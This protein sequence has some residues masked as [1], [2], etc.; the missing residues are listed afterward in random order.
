MGKNHHEPFK[1]LSG[2]EWDQVA[3][4]D[5][6]DFLDTTFTDALAVVDSIPVP[7]TTAISASASS[8]SSPDPSSASASTGGRARAHTD[9]A[10]RDV[11]LD[12]VRK[13]AASATPRRQ[14]AEAMARA[15][16]LRKEWKE[17]KVG[18]AGTPE[19][20]LGINVY[21]LGAKD[22]RGSWFARRSVHADLSFDRWRLG[23]EHEFAETMK[24]QTGPGGGSIRG[25]GAERVVERHV[26]ET[27]GRAEVFQLSAQFPGPTAPRDFITLLLSSDAQAQSKSADC[28]REFIIVSKPCVHPECPPR[29]G[30]I[31]GQYESVE[32]IREIPIATSTPPEVK[33]VRSSAEMGQENERPNTKSDSDLAVRRSEEQ[34]VAN[35]T[36]DTTS[37]AKVPVAIEWIMVTRSDPGGSVPRFM[38]ERGTP[39]AIVTDAGKFAKWLAS[40]A[41]H[42]EN[43]AEGRRGSRSSL[44][45]QRSAQ[46]IKP[47]TPGAI[48]EGKEGGEAVEEEEDY[49]DDDALSDTSSQRSQHVPSSNGLYG[50]IASAIGAAGSAVTSRLPNPFAVSHAD[51]FTPSAG[52]DRTAEPGDDEEEDDDDD[53]TISDASSSRSFASALE[54]SQLEA[55][56]P[57]SLASHRTDSSSTIPHAASIHSNS[58]GSIDG[59]VGKPPAAG[60][61]PAHG[62]RE[63]RK[64]EEK[65]IKLN[66]RIRRTQDRMSSKRH[67][68]RDK[69][70]AALARLREKHERDLAK[71]EDKYRREMERLARKREAEERKAEERRRKTEDREERNRLAMEMDK[72]IA[73][74][75]LARRQAEMLREQVGQLQRENTMLVAELGRAGVRPKPV[76]SQQPRG[77]STSLVSTSDVVAG[78]RTTMQDRSGSR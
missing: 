58:N 64:L 26:A 36:S 32:M 57:P 21:K 27:V 31:R 11:D 16:E 50:V 66:E 65:R 30:F 47:A 45:R 62:D 43:K 8:P 22:G 15:Q 38:I 41:A 78:D 35:G 29:Q 28:L 20:P 72:I 7:P 25:I 23:L 34:E 76:H 61:K 40:K 67:E 73:E 9:S 6:S 14:N 53:Q 46:P 75:D 33:R 39:G 24:V 51:S 74:R 69:D 52:G 55:M 77:S 63:L 56:S 17:V 3:S 12:G 49:D 18:A 19:N 10:L 1:A 60:L 70:A 71:H 44:S 59:I 54:T 48:S 4:T 2:I 5:L 42:E 37:K 13:A 68:D